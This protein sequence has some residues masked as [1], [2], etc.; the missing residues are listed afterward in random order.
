MNLSNKIFGLKLFIPRI[1]V[2]LICVSTFT[3][4][5]LGQK[6]S[7]ISKDNDASLVRPTPVVLGDNPDCANLNA[8]A[9]AQY[10]HITSNFEFKYDAEPPNNVTIMPAFNNSG[11][12]ELK[13]GAGPSSNTV[14]IRAY[15][16]S[17]G[18]D[19]NTFDFSSTQ[20]ITA[21]IVKSS[22]DSN[23]YLY[24]PGTFG[25]DPDGFGLTTD[26]GQAISHISF[27][28]NS[29]TLAGEGSISGRVL[30]SNGRGIS[31]AYLSVTNPETGE[32]SIALTNPFGYYTVENLEVGKF[33]VVRI[34]HKTYSFTETTRALSLNESIADVDFVANP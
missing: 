26:T 3:N 21:V 11:P 23:V 5:T 1:L 30:T 19:V 2:F 33:Y 32:A 27:C 20:F 9:G 13:G 34:K 7:R 18:S 17:P 15:R 24:A 22:G 12:G 29:A 6:A 8:R 16:N 31:K 4:F 25:G 14:T 28:F 10:A